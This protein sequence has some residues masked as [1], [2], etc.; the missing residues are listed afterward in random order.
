MATQVEFSKTQAQNR[1]VYTSGDGQYTYANQELL[2][3]PSRF[4][5]G[6]DATWDYSQ[7]NPINPYDVFVDMSVRPTNGTGFVVNS[8]LFVMFNGVSLVGYANRLW[9]ATGAKWFTKKYFRVKVSC[10]DPL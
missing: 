9:R 2:R 1:T 4:E 10:E 8:F 5:A 3:D 6:N 7:G